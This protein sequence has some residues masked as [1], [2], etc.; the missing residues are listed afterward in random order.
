MGTFE[1]S[2]LSLALPEDWGLLVV[3]GGWIAR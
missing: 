2:R 3:D 1:R